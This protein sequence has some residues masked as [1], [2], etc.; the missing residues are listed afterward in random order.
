MRVT[1]TIA[2]TTHER[3]RQPLPWQST[4]W[5]KVWNR[6]SRIEGL[7][8]LARYLD[9]NL[10]RGYIR[11]RGLAATGL[12][13]ALGLL[14]MNIRRLHK[15]HTTRGLDDPWRLTLGEQPDDRPS[16]TT[17]PTAA[18]A[19]PSTGRSRGNTKRSRHLLN[20][21]MQQG[22]AHCQSPAPACA[23]SGLLFASSRRAAQDPGHP[24]S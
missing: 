24:G 1:V 10:N 19:A 14:G 8:G 5:A 20:K 7:N 16:T 12:L 23:E 22:V 6:R 3:D 18:N 11:C 17:E 15:W 13:T 4:A 9:V 2:V 21:D